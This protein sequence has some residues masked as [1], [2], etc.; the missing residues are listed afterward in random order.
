[1][2]VDPGQFILIK[3]LYSSVTE[4]RQDLSL[5]LSFAELCLGSFWIT[6]ASFP[7]SQTV[8]STLLQFS[9]TYQVS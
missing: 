6:S 8:I 5:K 4:L 2:M 7:F 3:D 9:T 1:M